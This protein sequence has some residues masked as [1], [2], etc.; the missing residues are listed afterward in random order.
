M[1]EV[2]KILTSLDCIRSSELMKRDSQETLSVKNCLGVA[3][4]LEFQLEKSFKRKYTFFT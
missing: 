3:C 1:S 4:E 2:N